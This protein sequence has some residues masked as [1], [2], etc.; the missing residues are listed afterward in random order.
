L[1]PTNRRRHQIQEETMIT[2]GDITWA[3][4]FDC[5]AA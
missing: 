5:E 2:S 3:T 1:L 4:L